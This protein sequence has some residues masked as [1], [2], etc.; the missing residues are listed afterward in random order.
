[1]RGLLFYRQASNRPPLRT[2]HMLLHSRPEASVTDPFRISQRALGIKASGIRKFFELGLSMKN[3]IDLS[4]GQAHFDVPDE[5]KAA[6]IYAI[7]EGKNRYTVTQGIPGLRTPVSY[8]F[9]PVSPMPVPQDAPKHVGTF[10]P[11]SSSRR[12]GANL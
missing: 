12:G 10:A 3:P 1:M 6:A 11:L 8:P 4:I 5:V 7:N 2:S 9:C